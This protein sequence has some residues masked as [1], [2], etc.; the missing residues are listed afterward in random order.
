MLMILHENRA[1][2][3]AFFFSIIRNLFG[4]NYGVLFTHAV[5]GESSY[6]RGFILRFFYR[7]KVIHPEYKEITATCS[8]GGM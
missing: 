5:W 4:A 6:R 7:N 1:C 3:S 8:C 2:L